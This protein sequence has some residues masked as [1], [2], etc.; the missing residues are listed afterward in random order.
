MLIVTCVFAR[1]Y[2]VCIE[3]SEGE[4]Q[5]VEVVLFLSVTFLL[6]EEYVWEP[7]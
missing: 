1:L 3:F 2:L 5:S 7:W 6:S 4:K